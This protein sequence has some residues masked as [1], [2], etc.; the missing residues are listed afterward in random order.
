MF[1][2]AIVGCGMIARFH[3]RALAEIPGAKVVALIDKDRAYAQ[4]LAADL[5][6]SC[7][8]YGDLA[9]RALRVPTC[10]A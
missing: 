2:C 1:G 6:L 9:P 8:T 7:D 5:G 10:I 4:K 3:V